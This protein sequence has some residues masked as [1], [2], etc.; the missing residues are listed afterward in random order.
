MRALLGTIVGLV[1][2]G[3]LVVVLGAFAGIS[4]YWVIIPVGLVTG[5]AMKAVASSGKPS[6][7]RGGLAAATTLLAMLG[8]QLVSAEVI[9][10]RSP[11]KEMLAKVAKEKAANVEAD[12]SGAAE[13]AVMP[14]LEDRRANSVTGAA[15]SIGAPRSDYNVLDAVYLAVGAL[16]AYQLGKGSESASTE[17]ELDGEP[18]SEGEPEDGAEPTSEDQ[19]A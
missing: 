3:A 18:Q 19:P 13:P 12:G 6:L 1:L 2:G 5:L 7:V 10:S 4:A 9:K 11:P 17:A 16:V 15:G 8:G 14:V